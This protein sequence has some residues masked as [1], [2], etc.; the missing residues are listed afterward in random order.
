MDRPGA[1]LLQGSSGKSEGGAR[2]NHVIEEDRNLVQHYI[3]PHVVKEEL[4]TLCLLHRQ[5][6]FRFVLEQSEI[7]PHASDE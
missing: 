1:F 2:V 3:I 7:C 6:E 5:R 4:H